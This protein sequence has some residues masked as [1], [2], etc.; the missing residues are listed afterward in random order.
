MDQQEL[1][2]ILC[3]RFLIPRGETVDGKFCY[4]SLLE[5]YLDALEVDR[6]PVDGTCPLI[7]TGKKPSNSKPSKF[8]NSPIGVNYLYAVGKDIAAFLELPDP[9][10]YTGHCFRR[11]SVTVM[12]NAGATVLELKQKCHWKND[13]MANVYVANSDANMNKMAKLLTGVDTNENEIKT[14]AA[15]ISGGSEESASI[16]GGS[17]ESAYIS[18]GFNKRPSISGGSEERVSISDGFNE[19]AKKRSKCDSVDPNFF[20]KSFTDGSPPSVFNPNEFSSIFSGNSIGNCTINI[21]LAPK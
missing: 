9:S 19:P 7:R 1:T 15:S 3:S 13:K 12:A 4:A 17:E 5:T 14:E 21:T 6:V 10:R 16:S 20:V 8:I 11:T 18:G 2:F